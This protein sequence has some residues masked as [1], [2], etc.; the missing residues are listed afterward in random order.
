MQALPKENRELARANAILQDAAA[1]SGLRSAAKRGRGVRGCSPSSWRR[2]DLRSVPG[3]PVRVR[4]AMARLVCARRL[5]DNAI[6]PV[7]LEVFNANYRVYGRRKTKAARR[8]PR[9]RS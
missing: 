5:T 3:R 4:S 9:Q 2:A 1:F 7:L 6:K 8:G